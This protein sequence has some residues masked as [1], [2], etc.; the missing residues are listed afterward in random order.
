MVLLKVKGVPSGTKVAPMGASQRTTGFDI[1]H[2]GSGQSR[3][4]EGPAWASASTRVTEGE[5]IADASSGLSKGDR[6]AG[7]RATSGP[8]VRN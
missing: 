3:N 8:P 4:A 1:G 5:D 7:W 6:G 2:E